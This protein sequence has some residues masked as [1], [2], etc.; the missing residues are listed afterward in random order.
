MSCH[1]LLF[2]DRTGSPCTAPPPPPSLPLLRRPYPHTTGGMRDASSSVAW[3]HEIFSRTKGDPY[4]DMR[5]WVVFLVDDVCKPRIRSVQDP[6]RVCGMGPSV[7][8]AHPGRA[9]MA[10]AS[11]RFTPCQVA[12]STH[13]L[14]RLIRPLLAHPG[15]SRGQTKD[16]NTSARSSRQSPIVKPSDRISS[17]AKRHVTE[18]DEKRW[19][20]VLTQCTQGHRPRLRD[21]LPLFS[22]SRH[23]WP[24]VLLY[25]SRQCSL[26]SRSGMQCST[27][28]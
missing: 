26:A 11:Q 10:E 20:S 13:L 5:G 12:C 27:R 16:R 3:S 25:W 19:S 17:I 24:P 4:I 14:I 28:R 21:I 6:W 7:C 9:R 8:G 2:L 15:D 22:W 1:E 23:W 18:S